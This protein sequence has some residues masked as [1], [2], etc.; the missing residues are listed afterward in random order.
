[1]IGF[2]RF[3]SLSLVVLFSCSAMA[4]QGLPELPEL[5][6]GSLDVPPLPPADDEF[7]DAFSDDAPPPLPL[8]EGTPLEP[9][10]LAIPVPTYEPVINEPAVEE[11]ALEIE[12]T[13]APAAAVPDDLPALPSWDEKEADAFV[14]PKEVDSFADIPLP[15]SPVAKDSSDQDSSGLTQAERNAEIEAMLREIAQDSNSGTTAAETDLLPNETD[16]VR[17]HRK[18]REP[19]LHTLSDKIY[20]KNYSKENGHLPVAVGRI[21]LD[22]YLFA[23]ISRGNLTG[24]RTLLEKGADINARDKYGNTPLINSAIYG[25]STIM[26]FLLIKG[27]DVSAANQRGFT[28]LHIAAHKGRPEMIELL[29]KMGAGDDIDRVNEQ[30]K[31]ALDLA[32]ERRAYGAAKLLLENGANRER[33][34]YDRNGRHVSSSFVR[35]ENEAPATPRRLPPKGQEARDIPAARPEEPAAELAPFIPEE[36]PPTPAPKRPKIAA[37]VPYTRSNEAADNPDPVP[38]PETDQPDMALFRD[39]EGLAA[40]AQ[41]APEFTQPTDA[42]AAAIEETPQMTAVEEAPVATPAK[43]ASPIRRA[44]LPEPIAVVPDEDKAYWISMLVGW[45]DAD[46][47]FDELSQA[48]RQRWRDRLGM[49]KVIFK[50]HFTADNSEDQALLT[51][52]MKRWDD[53]NESV[54]VEA[55]LNQAYSELP[56][57]KTAPVVKANAPTT[58]ASVGSVI[59][60]DDSVDVEA[61]RVREEL[62]AL[63][64]EWGEVDA[65]FD[66]MSKAEKLEANSQR[67]LL[68]DKILFNKRIGE[69]AYAFEA[70]PDDVKDEF[71]RRMDKWEA[72]EA[73]L[74]E[75][76]VIEAIQNAETP[77]D[78][79]E[80]PFVEDDSTDAQEYEAPAIVEDKVDDSSENAPLPIPLPEEEEAFFDEGD[81]FSPPPLPPADD[82]EDPE[83]LPLP[84]LPMPE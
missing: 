83:L 56:G 63:L 43:P 33:H 72:F 7:S 4:Q 47:Q 29:L 12:E 66:T 84:S 31:T 21:D 30:G 77:Q 70:L 73:S 65:R 18:T 38:S 15:A 62:L 2:L 58:P 6:D 82:E 76:E 71:K 74:D 17:D 35:L 69:Y 45:M 28:A 27:A 75:A 67:H 51:A 3:L 42:E 68:L 14:A 53:V 20:K 44:P 80:E 54:S 57:Q 41:D 81:A 19:I 46:E 24:V 39:D 10:D 40:D 32:V 55:L 16:S 5:T 11:A 1:M 78:V 59:N 61:Q 8:D 36:T 26:R 50:G 9:E 79:V 25:Q 48:D 13:I 49:L 22:R 64:L 52:Y 34:V 60:P 37:A 23:A